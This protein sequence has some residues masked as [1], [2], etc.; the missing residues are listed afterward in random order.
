MGIQKS[1]TCELLKEQEIQVGD[2]SPAIRVRVYRDG[3]KL[4][5]EQSHFLKTAIQYLPYAV[6]Q[7]P[8]SDEN[9]A[10]ADLQ[11]IIL[12][13]YEQAVRRGYPPS[14]SWLVPNSSWRQ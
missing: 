7:L 3:E 14:P 2:L 9:S 10:L 1:G 13:F 4:L 11:N 8:G 5:V 6:D 12:G